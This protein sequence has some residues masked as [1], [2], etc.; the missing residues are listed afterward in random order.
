MEQKNQEQQNKVLDIAQIPKDPHPQGRK[1]ELYTNLY[2]IQIKNLQTVYIYSVKFTIVNEGGEVE[3]EELEQSSRKLRYE[4]IQKAKRE[5]TDEI[6]LFIQRGANIICFQDYDGNIDIN[7]E[8]NKVKYGILIQKTKQFDLQ[9]LA[10]VESSRGNVLTQALNFIVKQQLKSMKFSEKGRL[11]R[12]FQN[13]SFKSVNGY[14]IRISQGYLTSTQIYG[15]T[16]YLMF[17]LCSRMARNETALEVINKN[18]QNVAEQ[19]L[20]NSSVLANYGNEKNYQITNIHWKLKITDKFDCRGQMTS[21]ID[22]YKKQYNITLKDKNQPL[23]ESTMKDKEGN[24]IPIYL[25]PELCTLTGMSDQMR[26]D[27]KIMQE[28]AKFTKKTPIDKMKL[29]DEMVKKIALGCKKDSGL[30]IQNNQNFPTVQGRILDAPNLTLRNNFSLDTSRDMFNINKPIQNAMHLKDWILIYP[31]NLY[32]ESNTFVQNMQKAARSFG[33][34]VEEPAAYIEMKP[35]DN[36][37]QW[38][39]TLENDIRQNGDPL[40]VV[41]LVKDKNAN[42][43]KSLKQL[44]IDKSGIISQ[45]VIAKSLFKNPLSV[46]SNILLQINAKLGKPLW[47][48]EKVKTLNPKSVFIGIDVSTQ[49][50]RTLVGFVSSLDPQQTQYNAQIQVQKATEK[51][52]VRNIDKLMLNALINFNE[53]LQKVKFLPE[54]I[55]IFRGGA[56]DSQRTVI[57]E[58]EVKVL[59]NFFENSNE[60]QKMNGGKPYKPELIFTCINKKI[61]QKFFSQLPDKQGNPVSNPQPGTLIDTYFDGFQFFLANQRVTQG[62]CTPS[63]YTVLEN[64][65]KMTKSDFQLLCYWQSYMYFNWRGPIRVP[66]GVMY[67][68]KLAQ[69]YGTAQLKNTIIDKKIKNKQFYLYSDIDGQVKLTDACKQELQRKIEK[70]N[71]EKFLRLQVDGGEGCGGF[72]YKFKFDKDLEDTDA[73]YKQDDRVVFACDELTLKFVQGCVIDFETSMMRSAFYV[74]DNPNSEKD[75]S[76]K[77]SFTPKESLFN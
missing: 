61:N 46:C 21:Y 76:C 43:Y 58:Y 24:K 77:A 65:T 25:V 23:L 36:P 53:N 19:I 66:A 70:L 62:T 48:C 60:L 68:Q 6:G 63:L 14:P 42:L 26:G 38:V 9:Q 50:G 33:I 40:V 47:F 27:F 51:D 69:L 8:L 4:I 54:C 28:V 67:A 35:N 15:K 16:P 5:I 11:G 22:Y 30:Q 3:N 72:V 20:I 57:Q 34:Q 32:N 12:Y 17:E 56:G 49:G 55:V 18:P 73:V 75:C 1:I 31:S 45:H 2:P 74:I 71:N 13:N 59:K 7:V 29:I 52:Y 64:S 39:K 10:Q 37:Q 44:L 41:S